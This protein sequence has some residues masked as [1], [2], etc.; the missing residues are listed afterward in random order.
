VMKIPHE[1][2]VCGLEVTLALFSYVLLF[3]CIDQEGVE[4]VFAFQRN[5]ML[6]I[7]SAFVAFYLPSIQSFSV[8]PNQYAYYSRSSYR[9]IS[10]SDVFYT[11]SKEIDESGDNSDFDLIAPLLD[12]TAVNG[13]QYND[14]LNHS[15]S[16]QRYMKLPRHPSNEEVNNILTK[17]ESLIL[18]LHQEKH[19]E[20]NFIEPA[21]KEK[22]LETVYANSYV[23]LG[24]V[25]TLYLIHVIC[26]K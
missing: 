3:G 6:A 22:A 14:T 2:C 17:I 4:V 8:A 24:K 16:W 5:K 1:S 15:I 25:R 9:K 13:Y 18:S 19:D 23:D 11:V 26:N 7:V 12:T 20:E 10:K 21:F